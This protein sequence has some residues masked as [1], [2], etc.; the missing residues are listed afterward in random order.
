[1]RASQ[2]A[3]FFLCFFIFVLPFPL[4]HFC[5]SCPFCS[6]P[7]SLR[8]DSVAVLIPPVFPKSILQSPL[9]QLSTIILALQSPKF[10][11]KSIFLKI[12]PRNILSE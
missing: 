4:F 9:L 12:F 8:C 6:S 2:G 7:S 11:Q 1:M 3:H 10:P 5:P